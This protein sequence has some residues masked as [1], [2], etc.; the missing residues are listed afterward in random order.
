MMTTALGDQEL[1]TAID[2]AARKP[3]EG[4][5]YVKFTHPASRYAVVGAAAVVVVKDGVCSA[6]RV[7]IG[8][9]LPAATRLRQVE[10]AMTGASTSPESIARAADRASDGLSQDVLEDIYASAEYRKSMAIVYVRRALTLAV[11]RA[12]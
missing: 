4:M 10:S 11:A 1:L 12:A 8:G 2:V 3:G 7:A 6:A 5:A 9:L